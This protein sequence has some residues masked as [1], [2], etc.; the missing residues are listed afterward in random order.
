MRTA[1]IGTGH[2]GLLTA[3]TLA[4]IG[5]EAIGFDDDGPKIEALKSGQMPFF[6]QGLEELV[7]DEQTSGRL[8]FATA[9]AE[10]ILGAE[11]VF[12][13]V[14]TPGRPSGEPNML[15]FERAA[16][17]VAACA[18]GPMVVVEKSTVPVQTSSRV[19][20]LLERGSSHLLDIA[21]NPEFLREGLAVEDSLHPERILVGAETERA[22]AVMR[23]LYEP[24]V[25]AGAQYFATDVSSAELAKHACNAFLALKISFINGLARVCEAAGADVERVADIL[26][27]DHRIGRDFLNAGLGWG[28]SCFP[29]DL[30]AFRAQAARLGYRFGLLDEIVSVNDEALAAAFAK[31]KDA[32]WNLEGK[33]ILMLGLAFKPGTDD[34][35]HSPALK[36]ARLLIEGGAAVV[37]C[38]PQAGLAATR[39]LPELEVADDV[40]AAAEGAAC[41]VL[42][43]E[44]PQFAELDFVRLKGILQ[45]PVLIDCRN[46]YDPEVMAAVGFTYLPTGRPPVNR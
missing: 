36:L 35:R 40:Y 5:H 3:A 2:V 18:D 16:S 29:K 15:A 24:M 31:V 41:V 42:A 21:S 28:G 4:H 26:G 19:K 13:C 39:E 12:I 14:G 10:A 11:V 27:S 1:V 8:R 34:T 33:R 38:D 20:A 22:H 6:E 46:L 7:T 23:R 25:A 17:A 32:V 43:T 37:A 45:V 9:P 30:A 44:W